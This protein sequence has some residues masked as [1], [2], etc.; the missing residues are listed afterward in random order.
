[1]IAATRNRVMITVGLVLFIAAHLTPD[2]LA[3]TLR[4]LQPGWDMQMIS[5]STKAEIIKPTKTCV[6]IHPCRLDFQDVTLQRRVRSAAAQN[7][8]HRGDHT[9]SVHSEQRLSTNEGVEL[10][11]ISDDVEL[12]AQTA[13]P[14]L[15]PRSSVELTAPYFNLHIDSSQFARGGLQYFFPYKPARVSYRFFDILAGKEAPLDYVETI[16]RGDSPRA[17]AG[18]VLVYQQEIPATALT[19]SSLIL[20]NLSPE[21]R[22]HEKDSSGSATLADL[23][24]R[25][26]YV[27]ASAFYSPGS[28]AA[29]AGTVPL[30]P[31]Y[32][33]YRRVFVESHTGVI[34]NEVNNI[35]VFFAQNLRE[36]TDTARAAQLS[37]PQEIPGDKYR[38]IFKARFEWDEAT[39]QALVQLARPTVRTLFFGQLIPYMIKVLA[40]VLI[41]YSVSHRLRIARCRTAEKS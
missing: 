1:M 36:A 40:L 30:R 2:V 23:S 7:P 9:I 33:A 27:E 31:Y 21:G 5:Q 29:A 41:V 17:S 3:L 12:D 26:L 11:H 14:V 4:P 22:A 32:A 28:A 20:E 38:T 16:S 35:Y 39:Q 19:S 37:D 25:D 15:G 10:F 13:F 34:L 6:D 24:N 8:Q 18:D